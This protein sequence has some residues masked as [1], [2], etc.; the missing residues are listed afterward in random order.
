MA[1][2]SAPAASPDDTWISSEKGS[3][4][5]AASPPKKK[6]SKGGSSSLRRAF[7]WLRGRRKKQQQ[8]QKGQSGLPPTEG[9]KQEG[10]L[11]A[12]VGMF[13]LQLSHEVRDP[14]RNLE[15][16]QMSPHQEGVLQKLL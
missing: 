14:E 6:K 1:G 3:A 9:K 12:K 13:L 2:K 5:P 10:R 15:L 8:Q 16:L 4:S 7:S 11:K